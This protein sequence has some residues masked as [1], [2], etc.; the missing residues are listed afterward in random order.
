ML[1]VTDLTIHFDKTILEKAHLTIPS[2]YLT[3]ITGPSGSGKTTL[4]YSLG[5][6]SSVKDYFY[7]FNGV[8]INV[9]NESQKAGFR[10]NAIGYVFQDNN[11]I[12][13]LTIKENICFAAH[14]AGTADDPDTI[15]ALLNAVGLENRSKEYPQ[16]LSGGERQRLAIACALSKEPEL[17][18]ADEPTSA[19]DL[20]NAN[21][22]MQLFKGIARQ[23]K[24]VVLAS[25]DPKIVEQCDVIYE[26]QDTHLVIDKGKNILISTSNHIAKTETM[27]DNLI[28]KKK[29]FSFGN[30]IHYAVQTGKRS[31]FRKKFMV[32]VCSLAIAFTALCGSFGQ[33]VIDEQREMMNTLA[34]KELFLVNGT[35]SFYV[36]GGG[37]KQGPTVAV[38]RA[39]N[40][41]ITPNALETVCNLDNVATVVPF[42]T[43]PSSNNGQGIFS[44]ETTILDANGNQQQF[45]WDNYG[46]NAELEER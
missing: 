43:F 8:N 18:I 29:G 24:T 21:L 28:P 33:N 45:V 13:S 20:E 25:H 32:M 40:F 34:D 26:I 7:S 11:L 12:E 22:I 5:L 37:S 23:G 17:I 10:K 3:A 19:L 44:A 1:T 30:C 42:V 41:A 36:I 46:T 35:G 31:K 4:L 2:G 15:S 9:A 38:D 14:L 6:I 16:A 39:D 27:K